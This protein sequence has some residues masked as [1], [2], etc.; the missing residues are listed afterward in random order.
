MAGAHCRQGVA[1]NGLVGLLPPH[2]RPH[3]RS[4]DLGGGEE[5]QLTAQFGL[6][7]TV[8]R[9]EAVEHVQ[10]R[11]EQ[12]VGGEEGIGQGDPAH[13]RAA[14][15]ALVPLGAG[16]RGNHGEVAAHHPGQG[17]D[18]F[19]R[20][21]VHL[22]GHGRG[23]HLVSGEPLGGQVVTGHEPHGGGQAGWSGRGLDQ[24]G[25]HVEVERAG[26]DLTDAADRRLEAQPPG[27]RRLELIQPGEVAA[28]QVELVL[29]GAHRALE[30]PQRVAAQ[31]LLHPGQ[32]VQQLLAGVGEALAQGGGLGRHVVGSGRHHHRGV[33]GRPIGQSGQGGHHAVAHDGEGV[34]DLTLLHV[35]GEVARGHRLVDVLVA[36]QGAELL[37]AGLD[38]VAVHPLPSLDRRQVDI[39]NHLL[40]GLDH[41]VGYGDPKSALR[42]EHGD[43]QP[44]L[45]H[46]LAGRRPQRPHGRAGV[47]LGQHVG[48]RMTR[49]GDGAVHA[50]ARCRRSSSRAAAS[51]SSEM[52]SICTTSRAAFMAPSTATVAT[53]TPLGICTVA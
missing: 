36:G 33:L 47:A 34:T 5:R 9:S 11:L 24:S 4:Q 23:A 53:G 38:V 51:P 25:D 35:L 26:V 44:P 13:H 14:H 20:P 49:G 31:D 6:D 7:G 32:G 8:V 42:L 45:G 48:D 28:Q 10:E 16:E 27:D 30:A 2:P 37:D 41:P 12:A 1:P 17:S 50:P 15:V 39:V 46:H 43:P 3:R 18:P 19:A 52:A 21:R 22:V 40:V 29:R